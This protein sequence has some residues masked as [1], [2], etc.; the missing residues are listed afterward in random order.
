M[1]MGTFYESSFSFEQ[2]NGS[3]VSL[4]GIVACA[5]VTSITAVYMSAKKVAAI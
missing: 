5:S 3:V 4:T 1:K 2:F